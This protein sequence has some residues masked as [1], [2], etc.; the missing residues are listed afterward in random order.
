MTNFEKI[1]LPREFLEDVLAQLGELAF[2]EFLDS[3]NGSSDRW[4]KKIANKVAPDWLKDSYSEI[5][6]NCKVGLDPFW[7][8]G[9]YYCQEHSASLPLRIFEQLIAKG[10]KFSRILDV[11]AAPGGKSLQLMELLSKEGFLISNEVIAA[12]CKVLM[13]NLERASAWRSCV[14]NLDIEDI[15]ATCPETFDLVLVDAP[16]SGEGMFRKD[17]KTVAQW[18]PQ[19]V[20]ICAARQYRILQN[21]VRCLS[22]NGY[23]IYCTCT[24]NTVENEGIVVKL[25]ESGNL[26]LLHSTKIWPQDGLGEGHFY[27][28]FQLRGGQDI[29]DLR[30]RNQRKKK[31]PE[32]LSR[33]IDS[34]SGLGW[35]KNSGDFVEK[36]N[37]WYWCAR[38][39]PNLRYRR[40]GLELGQLIQGFKKSEFRFSQAL[41]LSLQSDWTDDCSIWSLNLCDEAVKSYLRGEEL[42]NP[43]DFEGYG[44]VCYRGQGLGWAKASGKRLR[45]LFPQAWRVK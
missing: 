41:A 25:L 20:E 4:A 33:L 7:Q 27:A 2:K 32:A 36:N 3:F 35:M 34:V 44:L 43:E 37:L 39:L 21:A 42:Q 31:L 14:T 40:Q 5:P 16:C 18:S 13:E 45:N 6:Q 12:R 26:E 19:M 38:H 30:Y 8:A 23:L 28:F 22:A 17:P 1:G 10:R 29:P 9:S 15:A 11:C 24:L